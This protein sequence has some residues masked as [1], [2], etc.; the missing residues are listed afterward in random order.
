MSFSPFMPIAAADAEEF[1]A[2]SLQHDGALSC[3]KMD[4]VTE[5]RVVLLYD[6][7]KL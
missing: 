3:M 5:S 4:F 2:Y 6:L 1:V 7:T